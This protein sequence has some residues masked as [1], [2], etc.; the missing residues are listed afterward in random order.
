MWLDLLQL[1]KYLCVGAV[2]ALRFFPPQLFIHGAYAFLLDSR[3]AKLVK[4]LVTWSFSLHSSH[5]QSQSHMSVLESATYSKYFVDFVEQL[6]V[7]HGQLLAV[8]IL[9]KLRFQFHRRRL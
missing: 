3:H 8:A 2:Y 1:L 9:L 6:L 7:S 5:Q 4:A